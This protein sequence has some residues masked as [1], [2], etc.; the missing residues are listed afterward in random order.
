M[1]PIYNIAELKLFTDRVGRIYGTEDWCMFLYALAKM[2]APRHVLELGFGVGACA[3][4]LAQAMRENGAGHVYTVDDGRDWAKVLS[5]NEEVF[6]TDEKLA[7]FSDYFGY[8]RERFDLTKQLTHIAHSIP[9]FPRMDQPIDMLFSDFMHGPNDILQI[10]GT[11]LGGMAASSSI[12]IDSASTSFPS[13]A[14]LELLIPQL[15]QGRL[16]QMLLECIPEAQLEA[17]WKMVRASRFDLIHVTE[18]KRRAQNSTAWIKIQ[19]LDLRAYPRTV[20]H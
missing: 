17:T 8:L 6:A 20:F 1:I 19:P 2:H 5:E 12:F 18:H 15:N 9:P 13:Y 4:W 7:V 14:L 3:L 11:Y 10:L 16:P